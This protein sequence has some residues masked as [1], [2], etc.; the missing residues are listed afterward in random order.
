[1]NDSGV[2]ALKIQTK[3]KLQSIT[4][5]KRHDITVKLN[6]VWKSKRYNN[7][8]TIPSIFQ[9]ARPN[10]LLTWEITTGSPVFYKIN[11]NKDIWGSLQ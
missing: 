4:N 9:A 1:M 6:L 2:S 5:K 7:V 8:I 3:S 10:I 11:V